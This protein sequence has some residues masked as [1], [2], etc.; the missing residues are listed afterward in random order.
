VLNAYTLTFGGLLL[1]GG[2]LADLLGR[3]RIFQIGVGVF[4]LGSLLCGLSQ[5]STM[6]ITARALQGLGAAIVSPAA[7]SILTVTFEEGSERNKALG[8]W[9]AVAGLGGAVGVLAGGFLTD[10][11]DWRWIF[12]VN[13]PIGVLALVLSWVLLTESRVEGSDRSFDVLGGVVGTAGLALLIY[14]FVQTAEVGHGWGTGLT[15]GTLIGAAALLAG[16][17]YIESK[18]K[19]PLMPLRLFKIKGVA[20]ANL[21]GFLLG[22][23]I[24]AM[25]YFL[26]RYMALVQGLGPKEIGVRYLLVAGTIIVAAGVSQALVTKVGVR[27]ILSLGMLLLALGLAY[28]TFIRVN[29]TYG[30]DLVPG[31]ILS[32]VGLGFSFI[33]VAIGALEGVSARDAGVASGVVNTA[34][35]VGGAVGLGILGSI[36]NTTTKNYSVDNR[37]APPSVQELQNLPL[38]LDKATAFVEGYQTAFWV[39]VALSVLGIIASLVMIR[40]GRLQDRAPVVVAL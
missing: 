8:V 31:F 40:G 23:A 9:G 22:C 10:W 28:F 3:R 29:G 4:T 33:P 25:F 27:P 32:G 7:L 39:G 37:I 12:W 21:V 16:F 17:L 24:F 19:S 38:P 11:L 1:L 36:A 5:N 18:A 13:V 15:A 34:Q 14:G 30:R 2:R 35:Q 20:G 6:L 26:S